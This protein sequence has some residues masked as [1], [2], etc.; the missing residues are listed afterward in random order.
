MRRTALGLTSISCLLAVACATPVKQ[1][2]AVS[3]V[4]PGHGETVAVDQS[5][6]LV[7]TS[8]SISRTEQFP[9][10]KALVQSL[11]SAMPDGHYEAGSIAF[12]GVKREKSALA[13]LDRTALSHHSGDLRYLSEGTPI[14]QVIREAGDQLKGKKGQAAITLI[15]DGMPTDVGGRDVPPQ[16]VLDAAKEVAG[17]YDGDLCFHTVQIG[18]EA[19][20]AQFLQ[21]L[22][23]T[24]KCGTY[25]TASSLTTASAIQGFQREVYLAKTEVAVVDGDD[26]EDGVPNSRDACPHTP[27][28]A[29]VDARGCWVIANLHFD[30][31]S[32][33]IAPQDEELLKSRGVAILEANPDLRVRI[34]GHTDARGTDAYNQKLSERRAEAVRKFFVAHGIDPSRLETRGFGESSPAAPND[35]PEHMAEN[36]RVEFTPL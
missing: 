20:G 24:T 14:D 18:N 26:D 11:V 6:T 19:Q 17:G 36:R 15:S 2:V 30:T 16:K 12:G 34:D 29:R 10:E 7:D 5:I 23:K 22:S 32:S 35:S 27:K 8:G 4:T 21:A 33:T 3:P 28:L 1:P 25:R 31:N 13:P 9:D